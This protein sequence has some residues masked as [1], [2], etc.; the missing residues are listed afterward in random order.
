MK[1]KIGTAVDGTDRTQGA[2]MVTALRVV[3]RDVE[4]R[5]SPQER[6]WSMGAA[7]DSVDL[8]VTSRGPDDNE[9]TEE[10]VSRLHA[11]ITRRGNQLWVQDA[12]STNGIVFATGHKEAE[13]AVGPGGT[14]ILGGRRGVKLLALDEHMVVLRKELQWVLGRHAHA[15]LDAAVETIARDTSLLLVGETG[16]DQRDLAKQIHFTSPR[17]QCRFVE[18]SATASEAETLASIREADGGTLYIDL[19]A[20]TKPL[21]RVALAAINEER[22]RWIIAVEKPT[23]FEDR[24][25]SG[26][27]RPPEIRIPPLRERP[28][29]IPSLLNTLFAR[30][31]SQ[32]AI[33]R[34]GD[35]KLAKLKR[36]AWPDNIDGLRHDQ[37]RLHALAEHDGVVKRAAEALKISRQALAEALARLG[38]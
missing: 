25:T 9:R 28:D 16:C 8:Y 1:M 26:A 10:L 17:R 23:M 38:I 18:L 11:T 34:I 5:L 12:R 4:L 19:A 20:C 24:F 37:K 15:A 36:H 30:A 35:D 27:R 6:T 14:F 13:G 22:L 21:P 32:V 3:G 31:G 33:E 29:D 7:R 2:G